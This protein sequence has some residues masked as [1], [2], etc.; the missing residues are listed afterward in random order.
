MESTNTNQISQH[1]SAS[2][3]DSDQTFLQTLPLLNI[4]TETQPNSLAPNTQSYTNDSIIPL[5]ESPSYPLNSNIAIADF[6]TPSNDYT[7]LT[8]RN[9]SVICSKREDIFKDWWAG[10]L[11]IVCLIIYLYLLILCIINEA[12]LSNG[13]T[14]NLNTWSDEILWMAFAL[15]VSF[16][17]S[18]FHFV[19][20]QSLP[21]VLK[22]YETE[23][24]IKSDDNSG[25]TDIKNTVLTIVTV[26]LVIFYFWAAQIII[27]TLSTTLSGLVA[28]YYYYEHFSE[29]YPTKFPLLSSLKRASIFSFGS[30][31]FGSLFVEILQLIRSILLWIKSDNNTNIFSA[32]LTLFSETMFFFAGEVLDSFNKYVYI[33]IAI[34]GNPFNVSAKN[35]WSLLKKK[36]ILT[37]INDSLVYSVISVNAFGTGV[38][39]AIIGTLV[40]Y[41]IMDSK[42]LSF[43][44]TFPILAM[45]MIFGGY[46]YNNFT[47]I[48]A[49][50]V[51]T[52]FVC[53]ASDP[54]IIKKSEPE[55]YE[56]IRGKYPEILS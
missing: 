17:S 2:P 37:I 11:F 3:V 50:G 52:T 42:S 19:L 48:F 51:S 4:S 24:I 14:K 5:Q 55:L 22:K 29:G 8:D 49:Y 12:S 31:C 47:I 27:N 23:H 39:C 44:Q 54:D 25:Y 9:N 43:N 26:C 56:Y 33:N 15:F 40:T 30:I 20:I 7:T 53:L 13:S 21:S 18:L 32:T 6:N 35:T 34:Y 1:S 16:V 46:L 10:L 41:N 38:L 45:G 28:S 36:R